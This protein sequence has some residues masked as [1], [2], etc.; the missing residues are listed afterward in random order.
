MLLVYE[1]LFNLVFLFGKIFFI[2]LEG[3]IILIYKNKGVK[4]N[5]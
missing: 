2:W 4:I 3:N 5:L 1:K